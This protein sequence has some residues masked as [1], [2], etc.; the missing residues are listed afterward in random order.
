[1]CQGQSFLPYYR[2]DGAVPVSRRHKSKGLI[3]AK[4]PIVLLL[5]ALSP[6]DFFMKKENTPRRL[7]RFD[8]YS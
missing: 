5:A 4:V 1:M 2:H 3:L 8:C 6:P 7:L